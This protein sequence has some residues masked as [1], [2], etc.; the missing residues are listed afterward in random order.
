MRRSSPRHG[1]RR[2]AAVCSL[3]TPSF[4]PPS[5]SWPR[6]CTSWR[7]SGSTPPPYYHWVL[8][9]YSGP[10][11]A[12]KINFLQTCFSHRLGFALGR[13]HDG[14]GAQHGPNLGRFWSHVGAIL[15]NFWVFFWKRTLKTPNYHSPDQNVNFPS[16]KSSFSCSAQNFVEGAPQYS[17]LLVKFT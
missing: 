15:D 17:H 4:I 9:A 8:F 14:F 12:P 1:R 5:P 3:P 6:R 7:A 10:K 13:V 16:T 2:P 11:M